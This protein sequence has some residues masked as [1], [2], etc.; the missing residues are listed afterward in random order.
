MGLYGKKECHGFAG[1][2]RLCV[3]V[4]V[5]VRVCVCVCV[6]TDICITVTIKKEC[7]SLVENR[8]N[9]LVHT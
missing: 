6:C 5:C 3:C 9:A 1:P 8:Q 4:C 7:L 2:T